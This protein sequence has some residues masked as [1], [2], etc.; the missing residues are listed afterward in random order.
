MPSKKRTQDLAPDKESDAKRYKVE[1][2]DSDIGTDQDTPPF[3]L[4]QKDQDNRLDRQK[5]SF[6]AEN[7]WV[8]EEMGGCDLSWGFRPQQQQLKWKEGEQERK[9]RELE[10]EEYL[11]RR[12]EEEE[13][14][15]RLKKE[16]DEED[17]I[18]NIEE[19]VSDEAL[20]EIAKRE[21]DQAIE[22]LR[23]FPEEAHRKQQHLILTLERQY[24]ALQARVVET[25]KAFRTEIE[26]QEV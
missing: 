13:E 11:A 23:R 10:Y 16:K 12:E 8:A 3:A 15:E 9:K 18:E 26:R 1:L 17:E 24:Q 22:S 14:K 19:P 2:S 5:N 21:Q 4:G 20:A 7:A 6:I 25:T